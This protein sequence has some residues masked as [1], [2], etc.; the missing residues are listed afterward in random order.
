M[1]IFSKRAAETDSHKGPPSNALTVSRGVPERARRPKGRW[2]RIV[3]FVAAALLPFVMLAAMGVGLLY[4]RLMHSPLSLP[5][6]TSIVERQISQQLDG[7]PVSI[8]DV[9]VGL[10]GQHLELRLKNVRVMDERRAL[11]AYAPLAAME[12]SRRAFFSGRVAPSRIVLI[13][14][15]MRLFYSNEGGLSLTFSKSVAG[16]GGET[17]RAGRRGNGG[18]RL[19][20]NEGR[21]D[22][23]GARRGGNEFGR[24]ELAQTLLRL[25]SQ[26]RQR[27]NAGAHLD[28]IG[29]R[30]ARIFLDH[31]G[32]RTS[33]FVPDGNLELKHTDSHS[34]VNGLI[35]VQGGG[36]QFQFALHAEA[37]GKT[38]R[39]TVRT[40][41]NNFH[42]SILARVFPDL[43]ALH[44]FDLPFSAESLLSLNAQGDVLGGVATVELAK[45]NLSRAV[46]EE[47]ALPN[48]DQAKFTI[49]FRRGDPVIVVEPSTVQWSSSRLVF[50]GKIVRESRLDGEGDNWTFALKSRDGQFSP[51]RPGGRVAPLRNWSAR[52]VYESGAARLRLDDVILS[53]AGG[54]AIIEGTAALGR[55][56][57]FDLRGRLGAMTVRALPYFWPSFAG[58]ESRQ[59]AIENLRGGQIK[60]GHFAI[61]FRPTKSGQSG[62]RQDVSLEGTNIGVRVDKTLPA[63]VASRALLQLKGKTLEVA[64]PAAALALGQGRELVARQLRV[65]IADV[66]SEPTVGRISFGVSGSLTSVAAFLEA[67]PFGIELPANSV[68]LLAKATKGQVDG[69]L[70][71]R[72]AL[73]ETSNQ[74]AQ[75]TGQLKL[76]DGAVAGALNGYD[77]TRAA[78]VVDIGR[79]TVTTVGTMD[80]SGVPTK[81]SWQYIL[82]AASERQ[83]PIRIDAKLTESHRQLLG[84]DINQI[85][86][87]PLVAALTLTPRSNGR[88]AAKFSADATAAEITV[89]SLAWHKP[90]GKLARIDFDFAT[91]VDYPVVLDNV[92]LVG[93]GIAIKGRAMLD[94]KNILRA[95]EI[96][97]F[98]IDR[99]SRLSLNGQRDARNNVWRVNLRGQT[100]EGR[101]FFRSLFGAGEFAQ[102]VRS[103]GKSIKTGV[104]LDAKVDTVLGFWNT[105]LSNVQVRLS[106]RQN[107]LRALNV[108]GQL[109][110][111]S[112][113]TAFL[114]RTRKGQR[115]LYAAS[116]NAGEAFRLVGFYPN[117]KSGKLELLVNLDG[118]RLAARTGTLLVRQFEIDD[119]AVAKELSQA[120]K[121]ARRQRRSQQRQVNDT[122]GQ[123]LQF[124]WMRVP[125]AV[126]N[127]QFVLK[128]AELRGPLVGAT[129]KGKANFGLRRMNLTGTY[130]PLQ[131]LNGA[132]GTIPGLGQ[133]LAGA[134]GEGIL[135]VT[136]AVRG[137]MS[138]PEF[139]VN[140][141]SF[142]AP[143]IFRE[144]FQISSPSL[145]VTKST[146]A[147]A[148]GAPARTAPSQKRKRRTWAKDVFGSDR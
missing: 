36:Q 138:R 22:K 54:S 2:R 39:L 119:A 49:R 92:R 139:L 142:I 13:E 140:P 105:K 112:K 35:S 123:V 82:K 134:Q 76:R 56:P 32:R 104:E 126:G 124:D 137:E 59:W 58:P 50:D 125:F 34:V 3:L 46:A 114:R 148:A 143:G 133:I 132:I 69:K 12:V 74:P 120:S 38:N 97:Q 62:A 65:D 26:A 10:V 80:V 121:Q 5:F 100:Y 147:P 9:V 37:S 8:G 109:K 98:T 113:L 99:V 77:V 21:F 95:F 47:V 11:V 19:A 122:P 66:Q 128:N 40:A 7:L 145:E 53:V 71:I 1:R 15:Q 25:T 83:L 108:S 101:N 61:T 51:L 72:T 6:M 67:G 96:P 30:R 135:G 44:K 78:A 116:E 16:V 4:M 42:P 75:I 45:A 48:I 110:D 57:S 93:D 52:G 24:I 64:V 86:R 60:R 111:G 33:W 20:G 107:K 63:I 73:S 85:V 90:K 81:L 88:F 103:G 130:V 118:E 127:G 31:S 89:R 87:G 79:Q 27:N 94:E 91:S 55:A 28:A 14:P 70:A 131:G 129:I 115:N 141:L 18:R 68:A 84:F 17:V 23:P 144:L 29:L 43:V 146:G 41:V 102:A 117:A 106:K 136:F